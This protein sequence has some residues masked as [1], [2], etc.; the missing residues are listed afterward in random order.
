[1]GQGAQTAH[2]WDIVDHWSLRA[3]TLTSDDS[4]YGPPHEIYLE[5][6]DDIGGR[7]RGRANSVAGPEGSYC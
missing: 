5:I 6:R 2:R 4:A 7:F 1:M 3:L